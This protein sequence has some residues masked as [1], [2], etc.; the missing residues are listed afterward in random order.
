MMNT[1]TQ[2][3]M[4]QG[5]LNREQAWKLLDMPEEELFASATAIREHFFGKQIEACYII[6]AKS[7]NCNMNCKFCSQSGAN[8][9]EVPHYPFLSHEELETI[10][11]DWDQ[12]PVGRCGIVTAG[13]ALT[14][15][16][17]EKLAQ[18]IEKRMQSGKTAPQICGS[19]GRLK[20][21]AIERLKAAGLTRLHHNLETSE[22]YYPNVCTTQ[23]WRDRLD[24]VHEA[25]KDGLSVCSGG[26]FGLGE[27]WED[28]FDFAFFLKEDGIDNIPINFLY[29]HPGTPLAKQPV[30]RPDEALRIVAI[31]RHI[32]PTATLRIC[33][34]RLSVLKERQYD[35]FAA[36]ANAFMT[37]NY[38]TIKGAGVAHDLAILKELGLQIVPE[39]ERLH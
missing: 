8:S 36:G 9:T 10:M 30:L 13:G 5:G 23:Q 17:V 35:M 3:A 14:D 4:E 27:T 38:L 31:F 21:T 18:F 24:T 2:L 16:D 32:N 25:I 37:G 7:G 22:S 12:Y 1:Y 19:L 6:N 28:R 34:G 33:G 15:D 20:K 39:T 26:L 29:P 11:N